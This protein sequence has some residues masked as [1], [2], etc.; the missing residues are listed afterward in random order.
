MKLS[1]A[2]QYEGMR[3]D[4]QSWNK[5]YLNKDGKFFHAYQ[6][7]AWLLKMFVCTEA[8]QQQRGDPKMLTAQRTP[9]K[10]SEYVM[11][12]FPVDSLGKYVPE[13][14]VMTPVEDGGGDVVFEIVLPDDMDGKTYE[15][16]TAMYQEWYDGCPLREPKPKSGRPAPTPVQMATGGRGMFHILSQLLSYPLESK[17]PVENVAFIGELKRQVAAL[18]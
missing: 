14:E 1:A 11:A 9:T 2:L 12:G 15:E 5:I 4:P 8:L 3:E 13:Y 7:S 6:W 18:L 10:D 17:T 16:L